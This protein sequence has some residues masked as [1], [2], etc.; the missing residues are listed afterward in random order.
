M[1]N[2]HNPEQVAE[3][4]RRLATL[5]PDSPRQWG[6][7]SAPQAVAHMSVGLESALGD[8]E[9]PQVWFGKLIG[10]FVKKFALGDDKPFARNAP[11]APEFLIAGERD[12]ARERE[13]L[14]GLIDRFVAGG[15][16]A[17]EGRRHAF[18]GRMTAEEWA[19]LQYKHLDHH[20]RQFGA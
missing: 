18:F 1:K 5:R 14:L 7:M 20:L 3:I 17:L 9:I 15:P 16:A 13:K 10:P 6:K 11:T 19:V 12:L 8:R 4:R 2:L